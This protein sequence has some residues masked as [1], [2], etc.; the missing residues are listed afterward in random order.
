MNQSIDVACGFLGGMIL[1]TEGGYRVLQ[2]PRPER[3]FPRISDA[4]WFLAVYWCNQRSEPAAILTHD[5]QFSFQ[6]QAVFTIGEEAFIPLKDRSAVF[7]RCRTLQ[8]GELAIHILKSD[9]H[10]THQR[11]EILGL[12]I[13]PRYGR[14]AI[15]RALAP[16]SLTP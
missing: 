9:I 5:G 4:R 10:Q 15:V 13:D 6:N 11:L 3:V 7:N 1:S 2:H 14:V 16:L 8:S 12:E